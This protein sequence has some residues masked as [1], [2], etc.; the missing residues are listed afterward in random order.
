[1]T[2]F[3]GQD[4]RTPPPAKVSI[5]AGYS[6]SAGILLATAHY[7]LK[8]NMAGHF[9]PPDDAL[10]T[11]WGVLLLPIGH[12]LGR[13]VMYQLNRLPG[14]KDDEDPHSDPSNRAA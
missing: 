9:I 11:M 13:V 8:C 3:Q 12:L 1:M 2:D 6:L 10:I 7:L 14:A 5:T 4:R